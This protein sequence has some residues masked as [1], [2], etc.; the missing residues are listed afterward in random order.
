MNK[1]KKIIFIILAVFLLALSIFIVYTIT[2]K[3]YEHDLYVLNEKILVKDSNWSELNKQVDSMTKDYFLVQDKLIKYASEIQDLNEENESLSRGV[4]TE[5]KLVREYRSRIEDLTTK[6]EQIKSRVSTILIDDNFSIDFNLTEDRAFELF[7]K[8][9]ED[10]IEIYESDG[11]W[12]LEGLYSKTSIYD[13][14]TLYYQGDINGDN[15]KLIAYS[16]KSIDLRLTKDIG[17][18]DSL[19][20]LLDVYPILE[21]DTLKTDGKGYYYQ[22]MYSMTALYIEIEND[23]ISKITVSTIID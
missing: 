7:G 21:E 8:S 23:M 9:I 19:E 12:N 10:K 17:V 18:G 4:K 14:F 11:I 13:K 5:K 1:I 16:T 15:Y 2:V 22:D 3:N 6:L 20:I